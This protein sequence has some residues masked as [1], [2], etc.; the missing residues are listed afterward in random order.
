M[1]AVEMNAVEAVKLPAKIVEAI[2]AHAREGSLWRALMA[3]R[4]ERPLARSR[5]STGR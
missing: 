5:L 2:I 3:R 4:A 1:N